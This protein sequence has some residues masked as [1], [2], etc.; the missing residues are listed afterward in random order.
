MDIHAPVVKQTLDELKAFW[1]TVIDIEPNAEWLAP[2]YVGPALAYWTEV[3]YCL[4]KSE[5]R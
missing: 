5:D 2:V 4:S 3:T 1:S